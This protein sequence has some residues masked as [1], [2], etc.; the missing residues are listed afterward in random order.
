MN[1]DD[2]AHELECLIKNHHTEPEVVDAFKYIFEELRH[3]SARPY[4]GYNSRHVVLRLVVLNFA[5][6]LIC[7]LFLASLK[8]IDA[9][10]GAC[11]LY[12]SDAADE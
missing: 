6:F 12:T 3:G 4:D 10:Y 2:R 5:G 7:T 8:Y 1:R 11:L 9:I